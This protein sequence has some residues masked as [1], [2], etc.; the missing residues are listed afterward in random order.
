MLRAILFDMGGTLDGDGLHWLDRFVDLYRDAGLTLPFDR[1]R[2]AFDFAERRRASAD[3]VISDEGLAELLER[4][5][6]WQLEHLV[7]DDHALGDRIARTFE[8]QVRAAAAKN[9][10]L[11]PQ[12]HARGLRLG[13]VSNGCGNV[14][15]L[16]AEFG[17]LPFLSVVIDSHSV[18]I[19]KPDPA[20][21][22]LAAEQLSLPPASILMVGDSFDRDI[23]PAK[24]IGMLTAWLHGGRP[25][26]DPAAVDIALDSL[27]DLP[28]MLDAQ[29]RTVA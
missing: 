1:L 24:S 27:T 5:V 6:T 19:A 12:L 22:A 2:S 15:A 8:R 14:S 25:C 7:I 9:L 17:F 18:G 4:H 3:G 10:E 20:I 29:E 23:V 21:Y 11:L 26:P 13:V 28:A 16:C